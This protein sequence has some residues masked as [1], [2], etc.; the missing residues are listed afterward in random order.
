MERII[1]GAIFVLSVA[2]LCFTL[3]VGV[4]EFKLFPYRHIA[5]GAKTLRVGFQ[6]LLAPAYVGQFYAHEDGVAPG[7]A[8]SR[9][10]ERRAPPTPG[11]ATMLVNGGYNEFLELCPD[12]AGCV[13]VEMD[14]DGEILRAWPYRPDEIFA[15]DVTGGAFPH[16]A[17]RASPAETIRP[18]GILRYPDGDLLIVFQ[19]VGSMFPFAG[20]VAR[21]GPDG[22]PRW[23]R[24]DYS[25]HWAT[26]LDEDTALVPDLEVLDAPVSTVSGG[27]TLDIP[28]ETGRPQID[29]FHLLA[30]D[31][32]IERRYDVWGAMRDSQWSAL[33]A[34][35][36]DGCDPLH[37]NYV[38]VIRDDAAAG[39]DPGD[40]VVS[41][42]NL[43]AFAVVD[44]ETGAIEAVARG[45]FL[46]QHSVHHLEG[47]RFLLF[48]NRGGDEL[49][50]PSRVV[51][52]D[53][54]NGAERRVA[55]RPD[56]PEGLRVLYSDR[57]SYID[58]SPD[59]R[60]VLASFSGEG[61]AVEFD[62]A[63]GEVTFV[64]DHLHDLSGV[65]SAPD[66]L[67]E[68]AARANLYGMSYLTN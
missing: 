43:S 61:K 34:E 48:D 56:G 44:R 6:D 22:R 1:S 36:T 68:N 19:S 58:I 33:L 50:P 51:E 41:L 52:F 7:D 40:F 35:T 10:F 21:I 17:V 53:L 37:V 4:A 24:F 47:S 16:E 27:I 5:D 39:L 57:G 59:R 3:G 23:F 28:C 15:A 18:L 20:G 30:G 42:R 8:A 9:R 54:A 67:R 60:R 63:T 2:V 46:Q 14:V 29:G 12:A 55:P 32:S 38:D 45:G 65:R 26:W 64:Y 62:I 49:G 31:G 66:P 25:H 13:A 11:V